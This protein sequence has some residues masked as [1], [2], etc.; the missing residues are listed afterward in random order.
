MASF[1]IVLCVIVLVSAVI[2]L[3]RGL[4]K[5]V[6]S[7]ISWVLALAAAYFYA[8]LLAETFSPDLGNFRIV[9]AFLALF[10]LVLVIAGIAQWL[11]GK[12]IQ[13][14]GLTGTDRLLGLLFGSARGLVVCLVALIAMR[15]FV[16]DAVWWNDSVF[17]HELLAFEDEAMAWARGASDVFTEMTE[18]VLPDR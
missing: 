6:L 9:L 16:Q 7:L 8:P 10:I 3:S 11:I 13:T 5:E 15:P 14:A 2:G 18:D 17:K 12:L 1:D 4:I